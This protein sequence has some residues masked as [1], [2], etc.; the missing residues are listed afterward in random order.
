[1]KLLQPPPASGLP[2][3]NAKGI[4]VANW[5]GWFRKLTSTFNENLFVG[6]NGTVTIPPVTANTGT[7]GSLTVVNGVIT[8]VVEP[9]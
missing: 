3:L 2:P 4:F 5:S 7:A 9:T 1:M 8:A 6:Y